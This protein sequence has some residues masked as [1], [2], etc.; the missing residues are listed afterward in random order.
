MFRYRD[1]NQPRLAGLLTE[2]KLPS[3]VAYPNFCG[4]G[5][6]EAEASGNQTKRTT[7]SLRLCACPLRRTGLCDNIKEKKEMLAK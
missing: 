2:G 3:A 6:K 7:I 5:C 1:L 4:A